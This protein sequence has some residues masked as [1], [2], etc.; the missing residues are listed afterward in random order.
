MGSAPAKNL[1]NTFN[2]L[3]SAQFPDPVH[4]FQKSFT[5]SQ[6]SLTLPRTAQLLQGRGARASPRSRSS[7]KRAAPTAPLRAFVL[8]KALVQYHRLLLWPSGLH[9]ERFIVA[10][11]SWD[12]PYVIMGIGLLAAWAAYAFRTVRRNLALAFGAAWFFV[13]LAPSIHILPIQGLLYEHWLYLPM[14]GLA[15]VAGWHAAGAV[16]AERGPQWTRAVALVGVSVV[17]AASLVR[18]VMRNADWRNPICF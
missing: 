17:L 12:S 14:L 18:T 3:D 13:V 10:P 16:F 11:T 5:I 15:M 2:S 7:S 6:Q 4:T 9:M 8:L 1:Q